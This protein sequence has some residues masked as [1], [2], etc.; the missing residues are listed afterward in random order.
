MC[1]VFKLIE[2]RTDSKAECMNFGCVHTNNS[3]SKVIAVSVARTN[4]LLDLY[5]VLWNL[6]SNQSRVLHATDTLPPQSHESFPFDDKYH[7]GT[8]TIFNL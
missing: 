7:S 6:S 1:H 5:V 3:I 4:V 2:K 8:A